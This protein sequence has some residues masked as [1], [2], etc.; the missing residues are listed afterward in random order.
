MT[1]Q[2]TWQALH[3]NKDGIAKVKPLSQSELERYWQC[4][5]IVLEPEDNDSF[6]TFE[7][8]RAIL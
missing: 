5:V 2:R 6:I 4:R 1:E 3:F 8:L 7:D